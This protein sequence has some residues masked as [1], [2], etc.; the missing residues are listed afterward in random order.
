MPSL[1]A[2]EKFKYE[3]LVFDNH[4]EIIIYYLRSNVIAEAVIFILRDLAGLCASGAG[5]M[6]IGSIGMA[7]PQMAFLFIY[8]NNNINDNMRLHRDGYHL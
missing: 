6:M 5:F 2:C 3:N 4:I 7:I 1:P 8:T